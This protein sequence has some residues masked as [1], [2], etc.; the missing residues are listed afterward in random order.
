MKIGFRSI[1]LDNFDSSSTQLLGQQYVYDTFYSSKI[2]R[3][4]VND[5]P[6][7]N[8]YIGIAKYSVGEEENTFVDNLGFSPYSTALSIQL[9]SLLLLSHSCNFS[10]AIV[11][12]NQEEPISDKT[13][14]EIFRIDSVAHIFAVFARENLTQTY[15]IQLYKH[16]PL[17]VR[18]PEALISSGLTSNSWIMTYDSLR[19]GLFVASGEKV[20]MYKI[21][22]GGCFGAQ[23][24]QFCSSCSSLNSPNA[25]ESCFTS[26]GFSLS[27]GTNSCYFSQVP[28]EKFAPH[29]DRAATCCAGSLVWNI[30]TSSCSVCAKGF[31]ENESGFCQPNPQYCERAENQTGRCLQA[32]YGYYINSAGLATNCWASIPGCLACNLFGGVPTCSLCHATTVISAVDPKNCDCPGMEWFSNGRGPGCR[33]AVENC[34]KKA[35]LYGCETCRGDGVLTG[36]SPKSCSEPVCGEKSYFGDDWVC[37]AINDPLRFLASQS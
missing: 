30:A 19:Q 32:A 27:S 17:I 31:W 28:G 7:T 13:V 18:I 3:L 21:D 34:L 22:F 25:C 16:Y 20:L 5:V 33:P 1:Y 8:F 15:Q 11:I 2:I 35:H 26:R 24:E 12:Q 23:I 14:F 9:D 37:K 36:I 6:N 29:V 10:E 4:E